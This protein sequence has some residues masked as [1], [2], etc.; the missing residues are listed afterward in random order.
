MKAHKL[1]VLGD[2]GVGK[3]S[4]IR[5]YVLNEFS[6]DYRATLGVHLHKHS[7]TVTVGGAERAVDLVLWDIEGAPLPGEQTMRYI[8]GSAGAI[9]VGDMTRTDMDEPM[10]RAA[11]LFES[12]LPGRPIGFAFNKSDIAEKPEAAVFDSLRDRY[13]AAI[14]CTSAKTGEAVGQLFRDIAALI[15]ARQR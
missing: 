3:T 1:V 8:T 4:L 11:D 7:D 10:R 6:G 2:F 14:T 12:R 15:L 5:R 9:V 13:G